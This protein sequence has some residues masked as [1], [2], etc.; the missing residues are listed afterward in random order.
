M[1]NFAPGYG[2]KTTILALF[3]KIKLIVSGIRLIGM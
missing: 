2:P 1:H 3:L